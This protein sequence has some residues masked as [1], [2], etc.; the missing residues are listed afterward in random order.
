MYQYF[1][2]LY[3]LNRFPRNWLLMVG[4]CDYRLKPVFW[5][6]RLAVMLGKI[7]TVRD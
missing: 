6:K 3:K 1:S 5:M 4:W 7:W 2:T